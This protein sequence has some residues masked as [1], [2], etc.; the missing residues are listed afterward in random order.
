MHKH[1]YDLLRFSAAPWDELDNEVV[2]Q[3]L[4]AVAI[5][6]AEHLL[7]VRIANWI[8]G[9]CNYEVGQD[10]LFA[11]NHTY[12]SLHQDE[13]EGHQRQQQWLALFYKT[14]LFADGMSDVTDAVFGLQVRRT[15]DEK[16]DIMVQSV[17][18]TSFEPLD[19]QA[20]EEMYQRIVKAA[21][22]YAAGNSAITPFDG[23]LADEV[24]SSL[25]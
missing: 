4:G 13:M 12:A 18:L 23:P 16:G 5:E 19:E 15:L 24:G 8:E 11:P 2:A 10:W 14:Q 9:L 25:H 21:R 7:N 17:M 20:E 1:H 6:E 22:A 3:P